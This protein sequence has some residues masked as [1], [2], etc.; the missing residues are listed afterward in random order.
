MT[1]GWYDSRLG[2]WWVT[3]P[4]PDA[5]RNPRAIS[6]AP[7]QWCDCIHEGMLTEDRG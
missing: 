6:V 1:V 4:G 7:L 3:V 2:E 5:D